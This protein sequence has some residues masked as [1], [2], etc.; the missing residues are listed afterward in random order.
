M[1]KIERKKEKIRLKGEREIQILK[2]EF[3]QRGL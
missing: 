3:G 2:M 1:R